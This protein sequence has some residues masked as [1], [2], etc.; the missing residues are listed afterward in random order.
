[1]SKNHKSQNKSHN[2]TDKLLQELEMAELVV[3]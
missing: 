1:M 2:K 3:K